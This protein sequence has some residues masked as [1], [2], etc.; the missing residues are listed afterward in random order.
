M[1]NW[2]DSGPGFSWPE[3]YYVSYLPV[4]DVYVVTASAD[5]PDTWGYCDLAIGHFKSCKNIVT[6]SKQVIQERWQQLYDE[7]DQQSWAY[8]FNV[9]LVDEAAAYSMAADVW[10]N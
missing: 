1:I 3:S 5:S 9:G 6:A 8:L 7:Y 4:Y 2:A 10:E